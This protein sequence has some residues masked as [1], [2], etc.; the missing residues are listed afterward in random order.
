MGKATA[1]LEYSP[2]CLPLIPV[3]VILRVTQNSTTRYQVVGTA[4]TRCLTVPAM[5]VHFSRVFLTSNFCYFILHL[6]FAFSNFFI[7]ESIKLNK[8]VLLRNAK[9]DYYHL[10]ETIF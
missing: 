4:R 9:F 2:G 1:E 6:A 5:L 10:Q 8:N 3:A 7:I